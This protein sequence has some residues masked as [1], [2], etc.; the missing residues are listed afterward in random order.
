MPYFLILPLFLLY[1]IAMSAAVGLTFVYEPLRWLRR[2]LA[3]VL[4]WSSVGF[5]VS[6]I[7]YAVG[8]VLTLRLFD[9]TVGSRPSIAGGIV[10]GAIL[11]VGPFVAASLGA[12]G[13]A[14]FALRQQW[15]GRRM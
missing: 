2:H 1:V 5:V 15:A 3:L 12:L 9:R 6:T 10:M 14:A 4:L 7:A 13:G 11:F 8:L